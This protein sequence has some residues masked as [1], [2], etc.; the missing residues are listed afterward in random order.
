M[1]L[2]LSILLLSPSGAL[3]P[4]PAIAAISATSTGPVSEEEARVLRE[5]GLDAYNHGRYR[6]ALPLLR[7]YVDRYPGQPQYIEIKLALAG[8]FVALKQPRE[9]LAVLKGFADSLPRG[10][11]QYGARLMAARAQ[12]Q[13]GQLQEALQSTQSLARETGL[14]PALQAANLLVQAR[15]LIALN[16]DARA[17]QSLA[18]AIALSPGGASALQ[19]AAETG[20]DLKLRQCARLPGPPPLEEANARDQYARRGDC[21]LEGLL[22]VLKEPSPAL[23]G[24]WIAAWRNYREAVR[25][26]PPP[27]RLVPRDRDARQKRTYARELALAL[28]Q[29]LRA[30]ARHAIELM[31]A[32]GSASLRKELQPDTVAPRA[33]RTR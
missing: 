20:L 12:L 15:A 9:A 28:M 11:Q 14:P 33:E 32:P 27:P 25:K 30:R 3:L 21:L 5:D 6:D 19:G 13:A 26:P 1:W 7:R 29:D 31:P 10:D 22:L 17:E 8:T 2:W 23:E 18:S 4:S 16:E 24:H